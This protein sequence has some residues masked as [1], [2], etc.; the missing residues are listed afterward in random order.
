MIFCLVLFSHQKAQD[1]RWE[2]VTTYYNEGGRITSSK[3]NS[4]IKFVLMQLSDATS[5]IGL[6]EGPQNYFIYY[7]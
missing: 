7:G 3:I 2:M 6:K 4:K 1:E 5:A